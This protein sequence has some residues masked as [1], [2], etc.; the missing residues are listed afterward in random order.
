MHF[1]YQIFQALWVTFTL[2]PAASVSTKGVI[3][4][5][6]GKNVVK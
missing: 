2:S 6:N 3:K 4:H 1:G 5:N